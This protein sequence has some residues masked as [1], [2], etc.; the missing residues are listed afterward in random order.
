[1]GR[2]GF[3][4]DEIDHLQD[5][6][7]LHPCDISTIITAKLAA[8]IP[9]AMADLTT[10]SITVRCHVNDDS[11]GIRRYLPERAELILDDGTA[12]DVSEATVDGSLKIAGSTKE[13]VKTGIEFYGAL[14][15]EEHQP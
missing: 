2:E 9:I 1:M 11:R 12:I 14:I 3:T 6:L 13:A 8:N 10:R 5:L 7:A 4:P 15:Y